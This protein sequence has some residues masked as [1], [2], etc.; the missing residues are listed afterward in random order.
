MKKREIIKRLTRI[1]YLYEVKK[2]YEHAFNQLVDLI[3][4]LEGEKWKVK[5]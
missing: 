5:N 2:E 3:D 1:A 4:D